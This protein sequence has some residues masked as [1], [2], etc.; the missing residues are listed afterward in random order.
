MAYNNTTV[1]LLVMSLSMFW[2]PDQITTTSV[3]FKKAGINALEKEGKI[4]YY[5]KLTEFNGRQNAVRQFLHVCMIIH[6]EINSRLQ[7]KGWIV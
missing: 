2:K 7:R 4:C 5:L 3:A 1:L 6:S